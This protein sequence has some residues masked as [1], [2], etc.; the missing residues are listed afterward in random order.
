MI[1]G[2]DYD[3]YANK[4]VYIEDSSTFVEERSSRARHLFIIVCN[5]VNYGVWFDSVTGIVYVDY[6]HDPSCRFKY[7]ITLQDH[8]SATVFSSHG[9]GLIGWFCESFKGGNVRFTSVEV[10]KRFE[11]ALK[12]IL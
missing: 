3:S 6:A 10:K 7:A 12:N 9:R 5:G 2:S 1:D 4:G 8:S 11:P